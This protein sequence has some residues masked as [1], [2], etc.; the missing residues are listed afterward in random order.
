MDFQIWTA[1]FSSYVYPAVT[2]TETNLSGAAVPFLSLL[3]WNTLTYFLVLLRCQ[4][5]SQL[6]GDAE[7][8]FLI[9]YDLKWFLI[10]LQ[11]LGISLQMPS[12]FFAWEP[13]P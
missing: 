5:Q 1:P 7:L 6:F 13:D 10:C 9:F 2:V 12:N 8:H 11:E 4:I 3:L